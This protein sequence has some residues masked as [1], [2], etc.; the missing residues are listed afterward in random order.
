MTMIKALEKVFAEAP[1]GMEVWVTMCEVHTDT[2]SWWDPMYEMETLPIEEVL[3]KLDERCHRSRK[4]YGK[5]SRDDNR[6]KVGEP[7][8]N[9]DMPG[10]TQH[11][12]RMLDEAE[13]I[14]VHVD[15]IEQPKTPYLT[16]KEKLSAGKPTKGEETAPQWWRWKK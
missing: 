1:E 2:A 7:I 9:L 14:H 15:P 3:D 13:V 10:Y 12:Y 5:P 6:W 8:A 4:I 16:W 11:I